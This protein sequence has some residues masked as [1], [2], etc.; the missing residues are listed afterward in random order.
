V[1]LSFSSFLRW[2]RFQFTGTKVIVN[3]KKGESDLHVGWFAKLVIAALLAMLG[4]AVNRA[5]YI[6][7]KIDILE[8]RQLRMALDMREN[9]NAIKSVTDDLARKFADAQGIHAGMLTREEFFRY[10]APEIHRPQPRPDSRP[11]ERE[12]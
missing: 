1:T 3:G 11:M 5:F 4:A 10:M 8:D 9:T 2:L 6:S 7:A 12:Y